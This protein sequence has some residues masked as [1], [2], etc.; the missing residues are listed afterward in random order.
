MGCQE[1]FVGH[2]YKGQKESLTWCTGSANPVK[3][4]GIVAGHQLPRC[5]CQEAA[6]GGTLQISLRFFQRQSRLLTS[7]FRF[8][9]HCL[10]LQSKK[11]LLESRYNLAELIYYFNSYTHGRQGVFGCRRLYILEI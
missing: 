10:T 6:H 11:L 8:A 2:V 9:L 7:A 5:S 4:G 1:D 3:T